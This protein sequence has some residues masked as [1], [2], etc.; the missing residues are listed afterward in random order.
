MDISDPQVWK[1][2]MSPV[3][4]EI[5][6]SLTSLGPCSIREVAE[7][8]DRPADALYRHITLLEEAGLVVDAGYRRGRRNA[9][10]L[11]DLAADDFRPVFDPGS[12]Q[13]ERDAVLRTV[14]TLMKTTQRI[15]RESGD[16]R[17]FR[18][19][20]DGRNIA[21]GWEIGWLRPEDVGEAHAL[22]M[23]LKALMDKGAEAREGRP[24]VLLCLLSEIVHRRGAAGVH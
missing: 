18:F 2:L 19:G 7:F 14:E 13:D 3:R 12:G 22:M 9:E 6:E 1:L 5:A 4:I 15:V 11:I 23:K 21:I 10:R 16:Q 17:P 20:D 24:H 8:L